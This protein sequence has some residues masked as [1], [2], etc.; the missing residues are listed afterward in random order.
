MP[1]VVHIRP[2]GYH[3]AG[4]VRSAAGSASYLTG[5]TTHLRP[6]PPLRTTPAPIPRF[7]AAPSIRSVDPSTVLCC[8]DHAVTRL[9]RVGCVL[10]R[11]ITPA[12]DDPGSDPCAPGASAIL[13]SR[14][15]TVI[16]C[17]I[18]TCAA[19]ALEV[20]CAASITRPGEPCNPSEG[21]CRR[22]AWSRR[23]Y[24]MRTIGPRR[25]GAA[26]PAERAPGSART[27]RG[28]LLCGQRACGQ[29]AMGYGQSSRHSVVRPGIV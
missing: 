13:D 26:H 14:L 21:R 11:A 27:R 8:S 23:N 16:A 6:C 29:C 1:H 28:S 4:R 10:R 12:G 25:V 18:T 2:E 20:P 15:P 24:A 3:S 5:A 7:R 19:P 22:N 17:R 9:G